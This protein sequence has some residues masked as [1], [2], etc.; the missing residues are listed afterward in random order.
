MLGG[1][2]E[3]RR[4]GHQPRPDV[5]LPGGHRQPLAD[6]GAARHPDPVR[7][8]A[9]CGWTRAAAGCPPRCSPASTRWVRCAQITR[10]ATPFVVRA[11]R[12]DGGHGVRAV[13][14]GTEPGPHRQGRPPAARRARGRADSGGAGVPRPRRRFRR[15]RLARATWCAAMN[16]L[17]GRG[18][19]STPTSCTRRRRN[20]IGRCSSGSA[21]IRRSRRPAQLGASSATEGRPASSSRTPAWTDRGA[22]GRGAAARADPQDAG[23]PGDGPVGPG[24]AR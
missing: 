20:G 10:P 12:E 14:I 18:R 3:G 13:R 19:W 4:T 24:A 16:E 22:A 23:R 5:A 9:H 15:A 21:R 8:V 2:R 7:P 11:G 6:L 17:V 1:G